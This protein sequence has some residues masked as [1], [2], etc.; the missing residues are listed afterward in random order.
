M[1]NFYMKNPKVISLFSMIVL[2]VFLLILVYVL[3]PPDNTLSF[4]VIIAFSLLLIINLVAIASFAFVIVILKTKG[5][6]TIFIQI[7]T[8]TLI[9]ITVVNVAIILFNPLRWS[10]NM[11]EN[12]ILR[13]TSHGVNIDDAIAIIESQEGWE[14]RYISCDRTF[15]EHYR[16]SYLYNSIIRV[17]LGH[18]TTW[19]K[20][21]FTT[22]VDAFW[23]FDEGGKLIDVYVWKALSL[24]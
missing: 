19:Y 8:T 4:L 12:H 3:I 14:I 5:N 17:H 18:Y 11:L 7:A 22:S 9:L 20:M 24:P 16:L 13:L 10:E 21:F 2:E 23:G 6:R 15:L 1:K